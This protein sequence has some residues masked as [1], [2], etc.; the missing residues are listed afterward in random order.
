MENALT[1]P[2]VP[3]PQTFGARLAAVPLKALLLLAAGAAALAAIAIAI[4]LQAGKPDL[5]PLFGSLSDKDAGAIMAQLT[6]M[7]VP[8]KVSDGGG[9]LV[10]ADRVSTLRMQLGQLGLP[11]SAVEGYELLDKQKFGQTQAGEN[12]AFKRALE[13][14][15]AR[16]IMTL[17]SVE[18]AKV[19]LG[20]PAASGFFREQHK[21][22]A[23]VT[24]HLRPGR[25]LERSQIAGIVHIVASSVPELQARAVRVADGSGKLLT[26]VE[27][28]HEGGLDAQQLQ[29]VQ[30][31]ETG[32]Q[33]R[34]IDLL[35][36]VVG[37]DHL[38]ASVT[39]EVDFSQ[40]MQVTEEFKPNQGADASASV[41]SQQTLEASEP[42]PAVPSGVPGAQ[43]NQPP[44]PASAPITGN[45]Q[46]LQAAQGSGAGSNAR[47]E[48]TTHF[49]VDKTQRTVKSATGTVRRLSTAVVL[50]HKI[51]V[52]P[53]GK[54]NSAPWSKEELDK[55]NTL[56]QQAVGFNKE[57]GDIVS[58]VNTPFRTEPK[59]EPESTPLWQQPWLVD[60]LRSAAAPAALLLVALLIVMTMV[61]PALKELNA[62][63]PEA[64]QRIDAVVDD[65]P[66]P[67]PPP[68][69]PELPAPAAQVKIDNARALAQNNPA[70]VANIVRSFINPEQAAV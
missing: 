44:V 5:R 65:P 52:D 68:A 46:A 27:G 58:V 69:P 28:D 7:N 54:T 11:K 15:L 67:P 25:S 70:A 38:R 3:A 26:A 41:K 49:E 18:S 2:L 14:E 51:S 9:L 53:K 45:A 10:P 34:L 63:A 50:N 19:L 62:A 20:L 13:G 43:S 64:P 4:V 23:G 12:H 29:Y 59:V 36:P 40:A 22:S 8:Y 17:D 6:Q 42:R 60:T 31:I 16:T 24:V 66:A 1:T 55:I 39:A 35:E 32:L 48:T 57:R 47:R 33:R 30:Q 21:P 56:A 37:R 61:R